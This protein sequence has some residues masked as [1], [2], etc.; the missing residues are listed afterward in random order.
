M[1]EV[2][3]TQEG[4]IIAY[5]GGLDERPVWIV[6]AQREIPILAKRKFGVRSRQTGELRIQQVLAM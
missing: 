3:P 5:D 6:A 1:L 4:G 2:S